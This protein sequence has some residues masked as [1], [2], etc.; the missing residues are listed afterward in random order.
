MDENGHS[1]NKPKNG[2][3][4]VNNFVNP[5]S[6]GDLSHE[7]KTKQSSK[8]QPTPLI[9]TEAQANSNTKDINAKANSTASGS[10]MLGAGLEASFASLRRSSATPDLLNKNAGVE[11]SDNVR[12][13]PNSPESRST[14][15]S[16]SPRLKR[17][18]T[19]ESTSVSIQETEVENHYSVDALVINFNTRCI[20]S[21]FARKKIN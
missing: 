16:S 8:S 9:R 18:P 10:G 15:S 20:F 19:V 7:N 13:K 11:A 21:S 17:P 14:I 3:V 12:S 4:H 1:N 6:N 2:K 5:R